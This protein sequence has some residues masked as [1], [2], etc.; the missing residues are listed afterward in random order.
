MKV[1]SKFRTL[2]FLRKVLFVLFLDLILC[3][4]ILG[5]LVSESYVAVYI[6]LI[7]TVFA[8]YYQYESFNSVNRIIVTDDGITIIPFLSKKEKFISFSEI[9]RIRSERVNGSSNDVGEITSGYFE[10]II[11]LYGNEE[12]LISP[13]H[14][15]NYNEIIMTIRGNVKIN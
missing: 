15:E 3:F 11:E 8:L 1:I 12:L 14:F 7:I 10:S 4:F 9:N 5:G 13:D 2:F 6:F